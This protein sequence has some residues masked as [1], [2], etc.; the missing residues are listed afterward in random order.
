MT[1][2]A[3]DC[4]TRAEEGSTEDSLNFLRVGGDVGMLILQL[5]TPFLGASDTNHRLL[6]RRKRP[7]RFNLPRKQFEDDLPSLATE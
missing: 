4:G 3:V 7:F 5:A 2:A 1:E 6:A